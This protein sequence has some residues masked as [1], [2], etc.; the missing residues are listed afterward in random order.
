MKEA[1]GYIEIVLYTE[2]VHHRCGV[3]LTTC[4]LGR[5]GFTLRFNT[6]KRHQLQRRNQIQQLCISRIRNMV[7]ITGIATWRQTKCAY[8]IL[9]L[10]EVLTANA[11]LKSPQRKFGLPFLHCKNK[12]RPLVLHRLSFLAKDKHTQCIPS[13]SPSEKTFRHSMSLRMLF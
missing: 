12:C 8:S 13:P 3:V 10:S 5:K 11:E 6:I 2:T 4:K 1:H 7:H 9:I